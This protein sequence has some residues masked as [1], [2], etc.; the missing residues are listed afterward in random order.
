MQLKTVHV[1]RLVEILQEKE[2]NKLAIIVDFFDENK[3]LVDGPETLTGVARQAAYLSHM[4]PTDF[5]VKIE[6]GATTAAVE[7]AC[8]DEKVFEKFAA[9]PAQVEKSKEAKRA[10]LNDF[11]RFVASQLL[12]QKAELIEENC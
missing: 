6:R 10:K 3:M 11:Q 8:A 4:K 12:K 5:S 1:G 7:K 2:D 9:I